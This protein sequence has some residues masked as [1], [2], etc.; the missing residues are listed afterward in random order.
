MKNFTNHY[1]ITL[2][3][4]VI[5]FWLITFLFFNQINEVFK[6]IDNYILFE[7]SNEIV[8]DKDLSNISNNW[9]IILSKPLMQILLCNSLTNEINKFLRSIFIKDK[10][11]T[12]NL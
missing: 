12:N 7:E 3:I 5:I 9:L 4:F 6:E 11:H 1:Q 8:G 10:I 2:I